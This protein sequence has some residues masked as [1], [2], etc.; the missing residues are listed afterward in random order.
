[1]LEIAIIVG[2]IVLQSVAL[3]VALL[4]AVSFLIYLTARYGPP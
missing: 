1:M 2:I 4:I 3:L